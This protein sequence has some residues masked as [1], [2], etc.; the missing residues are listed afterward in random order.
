MTSWC[1]DLYQIILCTHTL[2]Q[3]HGL[4]TKWWVD[5]SLSI[6]HGECFINF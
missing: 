5:L 1:D 3:P 6:L 4:R 2:F